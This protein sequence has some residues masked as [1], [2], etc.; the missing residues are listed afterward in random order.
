MRSLKEKF[1]T[2]AIAIKK[3]K[4]KVIHGTTDVRSINFQAIHLS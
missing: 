2:E 1:V 4:K 3:K